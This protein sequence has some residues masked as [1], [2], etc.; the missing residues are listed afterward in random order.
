MIEA[1]LHALLQGGVTRQD[2]IRYVMTYG[3]DAGGPEGEDRYDL[4]EVMQLADTV[5]GE[6]HWETDRAPTLK[7]EIREKAREISERGRDVE[8]V[9][10]ATIDH[11][12]LGIELPQL[13]NPEE[14]ENYV[15]KLSDGEIEVLAREEFAKRTVHDFPTEFTLTDQG[16]GE[17][18]LRH[19][20]GDLRYCAPFKSWYI[21][22]GR[23]W[24]EDTTEYVMI[25]AAQV[26]KMIYFEAAAEGSPGRREALGKWAHKSESITRRDAIVKSARPYIPIQPDQLDAN[27]YLINCRNGTIE[28]DTLKFREHRQWDFMSKIAEA[29]YDPDADCPLWEAHLDLIFEGDREFIRD[30]Q[31]MVGYSLLGYNPEQILF[32][33]WGSGR[34]GKNVTVDVIGDILHDYSACIPPEAL[35]VNKKRVGGEAS[36]DLMLMVGSRFVTT[37]ESDQG[38][39][40]SE[41]MIKRWTGDA[42]VSIRGLYKDAITITP[43]QHLWLATNHKPIITGSDVG[44]WRRLW[45]IPFTYTI[46]EEEKDTH[47][48]PKL[49]QERDGIFRWM[50]EGLRRYLDAGSELTM[51]ERV[52][53]ATE[54]YKSESDI[55]GR[56]LEDEC[57][58]DLDDPGCLEDKV[59]I[60]AQFTRWC[61]VSGDERPGK[62]KFKIELSERGIRESIR[63]S[64]ET[65]RAGKFRT[66]RGKRWRGIRL[67]SYDELIGDVV[68]NGS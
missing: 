65:L 58:I 20:G 21:W 54:E 45:L 68:D 4:R 37:G 14:Y 66:V 39:L 50:L 27:P 56:F 28:L 33:L 55:V 5:F 11:Y 24:R 19:R 6:F 51:P 40:L 13:T 29:S 41:S 10:R 36:P 15:P 61:D 9:I 35:M 59:L 48:I 53:I 49:L 43:T 26:V 31:T 62:G 23:R 8:E 30:F 1:Q 32:I 17:R 22:D 34:N 12:H 60:W 67:K 46:T 25:I 63:E 42:T 47:I 64:Y 52:Q 16:N 2:A 7:R 38:A 44:V 18:L 57:I 3:R